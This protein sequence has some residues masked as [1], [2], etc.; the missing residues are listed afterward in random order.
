[1]LREAV[2]RRLTDLAVELKRVMKLERGDS[3]MRERQRRAD[4][5]AVS[6]SLS[7]GFSSVSRLQRRSVCGMSI[8]TASKGYK[9][10]HEASA[11]NK[12]IGR[13]EGDVVSR[14][15]VRARR[16]NRLVYFLGSTFASLSPF[17]LSLAKRRPE[18]RELGRRLRGGRRIQTNHRRCT[19]SWDR[20]DPVHERC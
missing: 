4:A 9:Q 15:R 12:C 16:R 8:I 19:D 14:R 1:M 6:L 17:D 5:L 10:E 20:R 18:E 3:P 13:R 11:L 7:L 2:W